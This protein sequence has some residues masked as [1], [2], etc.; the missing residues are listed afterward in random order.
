MPRFRRESRVVRYWLPLRHQLHGT[1]GLILKAS[2]RVCASPVLVC[3]RGD[4]G[5]HC[6]RI[7]LTS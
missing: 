1:L 5:L 6:P 4:A 2:R 7:F 3:H